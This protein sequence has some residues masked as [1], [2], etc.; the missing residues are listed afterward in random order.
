[1]LCNQHVVGQGQV[2]REQAALQEGQELLALA[3]QPGFGAL[4]CL[5]AQP[6]RG[7]LQQPGQLLLPGA[8]R[9]LALPLLQLARQLPAQQPR[10]HVSPPIGFSA[11]P[12]F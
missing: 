2:A 6:L 1:M 8:L 3:L 12:L 9:P 5:L 4:I 11:W 7:L 10:L